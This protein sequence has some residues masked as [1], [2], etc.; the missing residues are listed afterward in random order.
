M[1]KLLKTI[2]F[3]YLA[4]F[5]NNATGQCL[6][7]SVII[8]SILVDPSGFYFSYDTN[9][10]GFFNSN[11]EYIEICNTGSDSIDVSGWQIGDDDPPPFPDFQ[12]PD[13]TLLAAGECL[14]VVANYCPGVPIDSCS[15]PTGVLNMGLTFTGFLGNSGDVVSIVDTLGNSCSVVYGGVLCSDVDTLD[16]PDFDIM[17]C[18]DWGG[19]IDGCALLAVGDSC[20]FTPTVLPI[21]FIDFTTDI[22]IEKQVICNWSVFENASLHKYLVQW[23]GE[24]YDQ[25]KTIAEIDNIGAVPAVHEYSFTHANVPSGLNY[26][27]ILIIDLSGNE[28]TSNVNVTFIDFEN[29]I[30]IYP[31]V[32]SEALIIDGSKEFYHVKIFDALGK[33]VFNQKQTFKKQ[34]IDL[35]GLQPGYYFINVSS[36]ELNLTQKIIKQ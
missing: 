11:D 30:I 26:Y 12:I 18:N 28:I 32:F 22:G 15:T 4:L 10:D 14:L 8:N 5:L 13:S 24:N 17:A 36:D 16:I 23:R 21:T 7:D 33:M 29:D 20:T 1:T 34:P 6:L 3:L 35:I 25:Y 27:R 2:I 31:T 19:D 9:D